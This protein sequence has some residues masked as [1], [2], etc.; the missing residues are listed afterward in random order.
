VV[1]SGELISTHARLLSPCPLASPIVDSS[2]FFS[3]LKNVSCN[4]SKMRSR[5][6]RQESVDSSQTQSEKKKKNAKFSVSRKHKATDS[7]LPCKH[8]HFT[9]RK[10]KR[11]R[12]LPVIAGPISGR[13]SDHRSPDGILKGNHEGLG[14]GVADFTGHTRSDFRKNFLPPV[15]RWNPEWN[16]SVRSGMAD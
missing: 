10:E 2:G 1:K 15:A 3:V 11:E 7:L 8:T 6:Q 13:T 14:R 9:D 5:K 12:R 4:Q 16:L